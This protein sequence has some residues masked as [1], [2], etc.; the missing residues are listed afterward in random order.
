MI[1]TGV[2]DLCGSRQVYGRTFGSL[3]VHPAGSL[4][5][6]IKQS[7]KRADGRKL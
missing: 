1:E 7:R 6:G 2:F 5:A 3:P 4:P